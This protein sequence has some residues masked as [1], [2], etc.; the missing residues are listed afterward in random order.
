M[1]CFDNN[2]R[3]LSISF[4]FQSFSTRFLETVCTKLTRT[5]IS[6]IVR[7]LCVFES[8]EIGLTE[9]GKVLRCFISKSREDGEGVG[10]TEGLEFQGEL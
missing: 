6:A 2:L 10:G 4:K 8:G 3:R 9:V 7:Y 1:S 5:V